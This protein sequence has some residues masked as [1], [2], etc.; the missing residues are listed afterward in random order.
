MIENPPG[1]IQS[2]EGNKTPHNWARKTKAK[3]STSYDALNAQL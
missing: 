3:K 1:H 2:L